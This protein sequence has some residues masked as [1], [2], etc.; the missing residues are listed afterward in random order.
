MKIVDGIRSLL[1]RN[2]FQNTSYSAEQLEQLFESAMSYGVTKN[3]ILKTSDIIY[4]SVNLI[5]STISRMGVNL[6]KSTEDGKVKVNDNTLYVLKNRPNQ[7]QTPSDFKITMIS[8]MLIY[9]NAYAWIKTSKGSVS[10]LIML[11]TTTTLEKNLKSGKYYVN[12]TIDNKPKK[13]SYDEVIHL[14]DLTVGDSIEGVSRLDSIITKIETKIQA[15]ESLKKLYS[16]T[17]RISGVLNVD[18]KLTPEARTKLKNEFLKALSGDGLAV[19]DNALEYQSISKSASLLD[20]QFVD[21]LKLTN[22]DIAMIFGLNPALLGSSDQTNYSNLIEIYNQFIQN[23]VPLVTKIEE[24]FSYKLLTKK[25]QQEG[26]FF[27]LNVTSMLRAKDTEQAD[28]LCKL[29][30]KGIITLNE[31]REKLDYNSIGDLGDVN[32]V[33]L[34]HVSIEVVDKYQLNKAGA[35]EGGENNE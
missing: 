12:T 29:I 6:Y 20:Q 26:H 19:T 30:E 28:Y 7:Y 4:S 10:E 33:D 13:L 9:G 23:L 16:N 8:T 32:R 2:K 17:T 34:N 25:K 24:E 5:A 22:Q 3:S 1:N 11:P 18:G 31:A 35:T 27:K 21:A 14:R 15:N